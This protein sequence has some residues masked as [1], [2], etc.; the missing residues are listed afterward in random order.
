[1]TDRRSAAELQPR[2]RT[3]KDLWASAPVLAENVWVQSFGGNG[4]NI[5][6]TGFSPAEAT[7]N[8][9]EF[10]LYNCTA[11]HNK[12]V[13]FYLGGSNVAGGR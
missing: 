10:R 3:G 7:G 11:G 2:C 9:T 6:A 1:M 5:V 12:G 8:A 4:F 13:G